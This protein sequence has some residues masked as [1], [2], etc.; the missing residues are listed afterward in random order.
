MPKLGF[1]VPMNPHL[2]RIVAAQPYPLLFFTISGMHFKV[3]DFP[4]RRRQYR[5]QEA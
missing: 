4:K 3:F 1:D 2:Q 5:E